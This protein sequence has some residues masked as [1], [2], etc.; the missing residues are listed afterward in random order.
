M[1]KRG[2]RARQGA[3]HE[4]VPHGD[5]AGRMPGARR[6]MAP[7][8][9][10]ERRGKARGAQRNAGGLFGGAGSRAGSRAG[11]GTVGGTGGV[12]DGGMTGR[13]WISHATGRTALALEPFAPAEPGPGELLVEVSHAALNFSDLLMLE[14]R[15]QVRPERPFT[16][17]QE[18]AGRVLKAGPGAARA[19]GEAVA[20]KVVT[21]GFATHAIV[22]EAWAIPVPEGVSLAEAAALP[23]VYTTAYVGLTETTSLRPGETLL[24]HAAAG[25]TGLA[26]VQIG[27][28]LGAHVIALASTAEKRALAF[29][30]GAAEAV[31]S[32][33]GWAE[34]VA[35]LAPRGV[36]VVFDTVGGAA[37][38]ASLEALAPG[39]RLL[40]VGFAGGKPA[41]IPAH[42]ILLKR[43]Q[44]L[45]VL[46]SH[47]RDVGM[48]AR[49]GARMSRDLAA[50]HLRPVIERLRGL[51]ALPEALERLA[52][53]KSMGKI[54][55]EVA[56]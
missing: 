10:G 52:E 29:E 22:P 16:A 39:G 50:G 3:S 56:P 33:E 4:E 48:L 23:V 54:V 17:G 53:R 32:S 28:G 47:D 20:S 15:Y 21:G 36:D 12:A 24:V 13:R 6:G 26:A 18:L 45:G 1:E 55:L 40:I 38:L 31:P 42:R 27:A 30:H 9:R 19:P 7:E 44:V 35:A 5:P 34:K 49:I 41:K 14:D 46:W 8:G 43:A 2:R 51:E 37:T 25:A 11:G